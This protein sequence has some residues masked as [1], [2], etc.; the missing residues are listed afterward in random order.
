MNTRRSQGIERGAEGTPLRE[1]REEHL[2]EDAAGGLYWQP[3]AETLPTVQL[4]ELQMER[5][6]R[7]LRNACDNIP[8]PESAGRAVGPGAFWT[9][10]RHSPQPA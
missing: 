10:S 9:V 4:G 5:L 2:S 7:T 8:V 6:R 3:A 1:L